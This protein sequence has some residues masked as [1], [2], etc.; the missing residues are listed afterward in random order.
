M[1]FNLLY[2]FLNPIYAPGHV[3]A[4]SRD[5]CRCTEIFYES[6]AEAADPITSAVTSSGTFFNKNITIP[7]GVLEED[8][9]IWF[10]QHLGYTNADGFSAS[11]T[12]RI[13][14]FTVA[15][16]SFTPITGGK[17]YR[18]GM[19]RVI[20]TGVS[21]K[22]SGL[23]F[24]SSSFSTSISDSCLISGASGIPI[25]LS[26]SILFRSEF[27]WNSPTNTNS[28]ADLYSLEVAVLRP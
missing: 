22:I 17:G 13:G 1:G 18:E 9:V 2:K 21:G 20:S 8:D 19:L 26:S 24:G 11:E 4:G 7:S 23:L 28:S 12:F 3:G 25:N 16:A 10:R 6:L 27:W 5:F 14:G 15:G